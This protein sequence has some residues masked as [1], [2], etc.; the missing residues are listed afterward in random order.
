MVIQE[1]TTQ[2]GPLAMPMYA[3]RVVPLIQQLAEIKV[4]QI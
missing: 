2:G 1:G 3:L 4:L